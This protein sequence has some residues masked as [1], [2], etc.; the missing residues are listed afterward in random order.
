MDVTLLNTSVRWD[1]ESIWRHVPL[2]YCISFF[3]IVWIYMPKPA[4]GQQMNFCNSSPF[5]VHIII[6]PLYPL[7]RLK[8]YETITESTLEYLPAGGDKALLLQKREKIT[9]IKILLSKPQVPSYVCLS[10]TFPIL[11]THPSLC[12]R[13]AHFTQQPKGRSLEPYNSISY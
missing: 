4:V 1:D 10:M 11:C 12:A 8:L 3:L 5:S 9:F 7:D 2:F 6:R 13:H